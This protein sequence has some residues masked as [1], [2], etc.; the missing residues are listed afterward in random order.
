MVTKVLIVSPSETCSF[1]GL[2]RLFLPFVPLL[3]P[4]RVP[5]IRC[6]IAKVEKKESGLRDRLSYVAV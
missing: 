1:I 4:S 5:N 2:V 6:Q 3:P